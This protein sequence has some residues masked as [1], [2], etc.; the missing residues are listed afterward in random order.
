MSTALTRKEIWAQP[1]SRAIITIS[2]RMRGIVQVGCDGDNVD[3]RWWVES[4]L[5][6]SN[7]RSD[8]VTEKLN[9]QWPI[10][11]T[12]S[13]SIVS[14]FLPPVYTL[15]SRY[16]RLDNHVSVAIWVRTRIAENLNTTEAAIREGL[17]R[18]ELSDCQKTRCVY[19]F[20]R[21]YSVKTVVTCCSTSWA[22]R[23]FKNWIRIWIANSLDLRLTWLFPTLLIRIHEDKWSQS[24][25][26]P[27]DEKQ[28]VMFKV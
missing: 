17:T 1:S 11:V 14:L 10:L 24:V 4:A 22:L 20:L 18:Y 3:A 8:E 12:F 16:Y 28:M 13:E 7:C 26:G 25:I 9:V 2:R 5:L 15:V 19:Q 21:K 6:R 23:Y 27:V